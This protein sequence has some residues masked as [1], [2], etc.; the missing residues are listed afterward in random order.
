MQ[1]TV[2]DIRNTGQKKEMEK[3]KNSL[4]SKLNANS[5]QFKFGYVPQSINLKLM[6]EIL[7]T[8]SQT[9]NMKKQ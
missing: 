1:L 8:N 4:S 7:P 5:K 3:V 9:Y 2:E 6:I